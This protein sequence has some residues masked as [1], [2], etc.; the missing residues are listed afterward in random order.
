L[1]L[2][3]TRK[4][5]QRGYHTRRNIWDD[6]YD[7]EVWRGGEKLDPGVNY[8]VLALNQMGLATAYSC[9]G[10]PDAFYVTFDAPYNVAFKIKE[11]GFFSVEIEGKNYWS[12]RNHINRRGAEGERIDAFRWAAEAWE[13]HFGPLDLE[14]AELV[15]D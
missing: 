11:A 3:G 6:A 2:S 15:F 10:H 12:I 8:F 1:H 5:T 4:K 14:A 13:K 7:L 9:E